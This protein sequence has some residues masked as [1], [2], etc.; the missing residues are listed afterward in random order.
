MLQLVRIK[1]NI[2]IYVFCIL[3]LSCHSEKKEADKI[4]PVME[5][6][7]PSFEDDIPEF[8]NCLNLPEMKIPFVGKFSSAN[9]LDTLD[10]EVTSAELHFNCKLFVRGEFKKALTFNDV[11]GVWFY[12]E[13]DLNC[14]GT[15][16]IGIIQGF[17]GGACRSYEVYTYKN[18]KWKRLYQIPSHLG[19][20]EKG[21]DYVKRMGDS[22][23][24]LSADDGCCQCFGL[25]TTFEKIKK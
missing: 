12:D 11:I 18:H 4:M 10:M 20:R 25:D 23:R 15:N 22:I 21:I 16:E 19:D 6:K 2:G 14:D 5:K 13:G 24:I 9:R 8:L 1:N 17:Y 7:N 3:I